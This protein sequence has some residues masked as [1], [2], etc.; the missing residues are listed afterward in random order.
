MSPGRVCSGVELE[1]Q[2]IIVADIGAGYGH[3]SNNL[4]GRYVGEDESNWCEI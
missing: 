4:V 1:R 2:V 3:L